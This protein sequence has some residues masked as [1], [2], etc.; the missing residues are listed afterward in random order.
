MTSY[1]SGSCALYM[2]PC[3]AI[4]PQQ[5]NLVSDFLAWERGILHEGGDIIQGMGITWGR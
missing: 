5:E 3:I 4:T 1:P 2:R